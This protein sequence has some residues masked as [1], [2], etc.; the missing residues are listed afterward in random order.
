M[1]GII[2][3]F[4]FKDKGKQ[5]RT[6]AIEMESKIRHRGTDWSGLYSDESAVIAHERL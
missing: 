5:M 2:G 4:D 6:R 1:C 3:I